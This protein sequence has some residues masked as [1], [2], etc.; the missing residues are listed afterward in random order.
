MVDFP[1]QKGSTA[2]CLHVEKVQAIGAGMVFRGEVALIIAAAGLE[3]GFLLPQ[4]FTSVVM[5][6]IVTTL[7]TSPMLKLIFLRTQ[8]E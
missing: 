3:A 1:D 8:E 2:F 7:V 4:Y 6:V 5:V